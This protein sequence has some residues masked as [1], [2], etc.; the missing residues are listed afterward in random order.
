MP[1]KLVVDRQKSAAQVAAAGE[2]HAGTI[3]AALP[4]ALSPVL[5]E[6]EAVPNVTFLVVLLMRYLLF[7]LNLMVTADETRDSELRHDAKPRAARDTVARQLYDQILQVRDT[8]TGIYGEAIARELGLVGETP[9]EPVALMRLANQVAEELGQMHLPT[10]RMLGVTL[11]VAAIVQSLTA[12]TSQLDTHLAD[13]AREARQAQTTLTNK[14]RAIAGYDTTYTA[15]IQ[16][17]S[18][19]LLLAGEPELAERIRP[20]RRR[21]QQAEEGENE[22]PKPPTSEAPQ[23]PKATKATKATKAQQATQAPQA[24]QATQATQATQAASAPQAPTPAAAS[25]AAPPAA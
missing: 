24:P 20:T 14:N 9:S 13:L 15:I 18:G 7:K 23:A 21:A 17:L 22:P 10:P 19:L 11:D 16:I 5:Q 1:S 2:T 6:G 25:T 8:V 3:G 12:I 4:T